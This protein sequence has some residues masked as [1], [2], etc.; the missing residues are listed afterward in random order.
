MLRL[1]PLL[2][3][4]SILCSQLSAEA[5]LQHWCAGQ[6]MEACYQCLKSARDLDCDR[7]PD[8]SGS[9]INSFQ[10]WQS[11]FKSQSTGGSTFTVLVSFWE[12]LSRS[13]LWCLQSSRGTF[14]NPVL[15]NPWGKSSLFLHLHGSICCAYVSFLMPPWPLRF[16]ILKVRKLGSSPEIK[17]QLTNYFLIMWFGQVP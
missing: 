2:Q 4:G 1:R 12:H 15:L 7:I 14:L 5:F 16:L 3:A 9:L 17:T 11:S 8:D 13:I 6:S 10:H